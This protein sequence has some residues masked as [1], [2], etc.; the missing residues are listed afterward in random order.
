MNHFYNFLVALIEFCFP[1]LR[2][3]SPK[4]KLFVDGRKNTFSILSKQDF[5]SKKIV[6]FHA[7]SLGEFEQALPIIETINRQTYTILVSFFS[8]SGYEIKKNHPAL[9]LAFYL[10]LDTRKNMNRIV[11]VI[12][13][14]ICVFIKYEIWP[15][16]LKSL[17]Q[18]ST[19]VYLASALFRKNQ[20]YFTSWGNFFR[21]A[22]FH[23]DFI[24]T[25]NH[26]SIHLLN[27]IGYTSTAKSGDTR[28]DR[29]SNQL[30]MN[31]KVKEVES[32]L[33]NH[34]CFVI[35]SSWIDDEIVFMDFI[36]S[37]PKNVKFVIAPHEIKKD[38]IE[39]LSKKIKVG[40]I[41]Y[42]KFKE[43]TSTEIENAQVFILDI[44]GLLGKTYSYAD[45]AYVGGGMG[46]TGLH[47][48]L[49][50]A[51]FGIPIIIGMNYQKFP[52]AKLLIE[53]GGVFSV[54]SSEAFFKNG[55]RLCKDKAFREKSG[56]ICRDFV[57]KN[58]GAT[59][60]IYNAIFN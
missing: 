7:S 17:K 21:K 31:N 34:K 5:K 49:E 52:E 48:I 60:Y 56:N 20:I 36:N 18:N 30:K 16:L 37:G 3:F 59:K 19:Q 53:L 11:H 41:Q 58:T 29:V 1:I 25:Q 47:N 50:P 10:P 42:S 8:P 39:S 51:T 54:D 12:Q 13:P 57:K 15:N 27:E 40:C 33:M 46:Y 14:E 43:Y 32:F 2:K 22:L 4:M 44:I 35:G 9:D 45:M 28:F 23:F 38:K 6:W 24:F 55:Q 26:D